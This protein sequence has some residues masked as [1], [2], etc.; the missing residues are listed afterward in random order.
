V[1]KATMEHVNQFAN[2][3]DLSPKK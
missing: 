3:R 1:S 2:C